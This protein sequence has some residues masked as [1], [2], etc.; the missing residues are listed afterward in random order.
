MALIDVPF[1][2]FRCHFDVSV[3]GHGCQLWCP[4]EVS[5]LL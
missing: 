5:D 2:G 1:G 3:D 4:L